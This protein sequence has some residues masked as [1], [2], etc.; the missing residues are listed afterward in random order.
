MA[1]HDL[2]PGILNRRKYVLNYGGSV[3]GLDW[4]KSSDRKAQYIA[5]GGYKGTSD[6]HQQLGSKQV[7]RSEDDPSLKG[8]LHIWRVDTTSQTAPVLEL[9]IFV[10]CGVA[11]GLQWASEC[12]YESPEAFVQKKKAGQ[13]DPDELPRLGLLAVSFGDGTCRVI[14]V[15]HPKALKE[16]IGVDESK[17]AFVKYDHF[18]LTASISDTLL[19]RPCWGGTDFLATG[20]ANGNLAVWDIKHILEQRVEKID[21]VTVEFSSDPVQ[22]FPA[23]NTALFKVQWDENGRLGPGSISGHQIF[24]CGMDGQMLLHDIRDPWNSTQLYKIRGIITAMCYARSLNAF[25][26]VDNDHTLRYFR[27][28]GGEDEPPLK[29][30]KDPD[31][32]VVEAESKFSSKGVSA[33]LGVVWMS[34]PIFHSLP[35]SARTGAAKSL[36]STARPPRASNL[37]KTT[38]INSATMRRQMSSSSL[39]IHLKRPCQTL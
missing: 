3:W 16:R 21:P 7:K 17:P 13:V 38:F 9:C 32:G 27:L 31:T 18:L 6:Q 35:Q 12:F 14:N 10:E 11:Y 34:R 33:H 22:Y 26:V 24:S 37:C 25:C 20:C 5:I 2:L 36:T 4:A 28:C 15:P 8:C 39:R 23:H 19:W 30:K 29:K 1:S